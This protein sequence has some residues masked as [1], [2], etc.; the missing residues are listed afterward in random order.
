MGFIVVSLLI[1][2]AD[3]ISSVDSEYIC[4]L[5]DDTLVNITDTVEVLVTA[6]VEAIDCTE[7]S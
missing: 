3:D 2:V 7:L 6:M 4:S 1:D 5:L